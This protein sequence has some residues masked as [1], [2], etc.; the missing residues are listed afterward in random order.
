LSGFL[1]ALNNAEHRMDRDA[2]EP[3]NVLVRHAGHDRAQHGLHQLD[4]L[5]DRGARESLPISA[6]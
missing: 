5:L 4:I 2:P 6:G 3:S 1:G